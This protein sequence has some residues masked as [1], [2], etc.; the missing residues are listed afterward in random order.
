M[1]AAK[2]V[3]AVLGAGSWGTALAVLLARNGYR[4]LFW[5]HDAARQ[6]RLAHER[7]NARYLPG[8]ASVEVAIV[9]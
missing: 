5:G 3:I 4:T 6:A 2:P 9:D 8:I 1:T 7:E